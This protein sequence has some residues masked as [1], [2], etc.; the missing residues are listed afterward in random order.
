MLV[1]AMAGPEEA[2]NLGGEEILR[3][4]QIRLATPGL[5]KS[6]RSVKPI[7]CK[8]EPAIHVPETQSAFHRRALRNAFRRP[9]VRLQSKSFARW[10]QLRRRSSCIGSSQNSF[11]IGKSQMTP[12]AWGARLAVIV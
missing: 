6:R 11:L 7:R 4:I 1:S 3:L 10:N 12:L 9:N 5:K 8:R 2:K